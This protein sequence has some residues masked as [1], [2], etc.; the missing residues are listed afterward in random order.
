MGVS[1]CVCLCL[2]LTA[3]VRAEI[4]DS[5][6]SSLAPAAPGILFPS[7]FDYPQ[8]NVLVTPTNPPPPGLAVRGVTIVGHWCWRERGV[9][10]TLPYKLHCLQAE[11][12]KVPLFIDHS[13]REQAMWQCGK[14]LIVAGTSELFVTRHA[15]VR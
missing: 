3:F 11:G 7:L 2:C 9:E 15:M 4:E 13:L 5:P 10:S 12:V 8:M 6:V 14:S 1:G